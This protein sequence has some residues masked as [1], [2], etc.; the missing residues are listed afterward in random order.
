MKFIKPA[1]LHTS[2]LVALIVVL[3][4]AVFIQA[5]AI[6]FDNNEPRQNRDRERVTQ[7]IP[8]IAAAGSSPNGD[9]IDIPK[10]GSSSATATKMQKKQKPQLPQQLQQQQPSKKMAPTPTIPQQNGNIHG[11]TLKVLSGFTHT[12]VPIAAAAMATPTPSLPNRP[13]TTIAPSALNLKDSSNGRDGSNS[14]NTNDSPV[15][16]DNGR[17]AKMKK[18]DALSGFTH[19]IVPRAASKT[20]LPIDR[21][22]T[23]S[24]VPME[25]AAPTPVPPAMI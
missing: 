10:Q 3:A 12:I 4:A 15:V 21:G 7:L 16:A 25:G 6:R 17:A 24:I 2:G 22:F 13:A 8:L 1:F 23:H 19:S 5:A 14:I 11:P 20:A 18:I 9:A